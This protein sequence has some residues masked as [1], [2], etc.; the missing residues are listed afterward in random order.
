MPIVAFGNTRIGRALLAPLI[1]G[2]QNGVL[3]SL[4]SYG[5]RQQKRRQRASQEVGAHGTPGGGGTARTQ[6]IDPSRAEEQHHQACVVGSWS[7]WAVDSPL[8]RHPLL[9]VASAAA[10]SSKPAHRWERNG[11]IEFSVC[12]R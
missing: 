4:A 3:K 11:L 1:R 2:Y 9:G 8:R 10:G 7:E 5:Q 6:Q 12:A